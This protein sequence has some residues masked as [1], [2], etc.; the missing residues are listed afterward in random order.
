MQLMVNMKITYE[1][2]VRGR[3]Q[4]VGYRWFVKRQADLI[5]IT[6]YVKN[7][8]NGNVMVIAQGEQAKLDI[9]IPL[10]RKGPDFAF[11]TSSDI[12]LLTSAIEY[13][14]FLIAV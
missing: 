1:I 10:V 5:G 7:Q 12:S 13:K 8:V 3:V 11:V 4:G 9:F 6:G 14:D 2:I